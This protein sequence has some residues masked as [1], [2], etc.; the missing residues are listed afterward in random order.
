MTKSFPTISTLANF[1][2]HTYEANA[3]IIQYNNVI[4]KGLLEH[5]DDFTVLNDGGTFAPY[6]SYKGLQS[7]STVL[8]GS[9]GMYLLGH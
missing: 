4:S 5:T 6:F 3:K 2:S 1:S 8:L 7:R 9:A